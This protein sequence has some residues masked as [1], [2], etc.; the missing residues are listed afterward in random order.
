MGEEG[1]NAAKEGKC[2][3]QRDLPHSAW[4]IT[5]EC[6][7]HQA[8]LARVGVTIL[9]HPE[10]LVVE[11]WKWDSLAHTERHLTLQLIP[12]A[13]DFI[14]MVPGVRDWSVRARVTELDGEQWEALCALPE[15]QSEMMC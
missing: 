10:G 2:L 4:I 6:L 13:A 7:G 15:H 3:A 14:Q 9:D 1:A 11:S 8:T 12:T 5:Q